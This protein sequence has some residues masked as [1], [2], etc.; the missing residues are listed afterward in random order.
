ML[1]MAFNQ[2]NEVIYAQN[3]TKDVGP[4]YCPKCRQEVVVKRSSRGNLFF[5]HVQQLTKQTAESQKHKLA[6]EKL[7]GWL[8]NDGLFCE[9][10]VYL[11][12]IQQYPDLLVADPFNN[13]NRWC[14]EFQHSSIAAKTLHQRQ[15]GYQR[16]NLKAQWLLDDETVHTT[17][18]KWQ[19]NLVQFNPRRGFYLV[20]YNVTS[21]KIM[22]RYDLPIIWPKRKLTYQLVGFSLFQEGVTDLLDKISTLTCKRRDSQRWKKTASFAPYALEQLKRNPSCRRYVNECYRLGYTIDA[23]PDWIW[24]LESKSWAFKEPVWYVLARL[25]FEA[26]PQTFDSVYDHLIYTQQINYRH[27]PLLKGSW[28]RAIRQSMKAFLNGEYIL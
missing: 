15:L 28:Q 20:Y 1:Y 2:Y 22:I 23:L 12:D 10:E 3:A 13:E 27:L 21:H 17:I 26:T 25:L 8:E 24:Q 4:F 9:S 18:P 7:M 6:K 5:S 19:F 16:Q 11:K 14:I